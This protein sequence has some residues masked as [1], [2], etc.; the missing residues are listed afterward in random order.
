MVLPQSRRR[1]DAYDTLAVRLAASEPQGAPNLRP[2]GPAILPTGPA[3]DPMVGPP[4]IQHTN[5]QHKE[6][7]ERGVRVM[8]YLTAVAA[9]GLLLAVT[10]TAGATT[11][12]FT[13]D[14]WGNVPDGRFQP[15]DTVSGQVTYDPT[16]AFDETPEDI[17]GWGWMRTRES[18]S[19]ILSLDLTVTRGTSTVYTTSLASWDTQYAKFYSQDMFEVVAEE[20]R[21]RLNA[22]N[23]SDYVLLTFDNSWYPSSADPY[24]LTD[25]DWMGDLSLGRL[26]LRLDDEPTKIYSFDAKV[27]PEPVTMAGLVLGVGSLVGYIRRRR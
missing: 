20:V 12:P 3:G 1:G 4:A 5:R 7:S 15:G 13:G 16:A 9:L 23:S 27:I 24:Y 6:T 21:F 26:Q 18:D 22:T 2:S 11:V 14:Y 8:R 17:P 19:A 10:G 25:P